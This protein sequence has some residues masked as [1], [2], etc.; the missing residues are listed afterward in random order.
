M[1]MTLTPLGDS[2]IVLVLGAT[3]DDAMLSRVRVLAHAIEHH[4]P[5]GVVD[6]VPAFGSVTVFYEIAHATGFAE[7]CAELEGI[8][9]RAEI[10]MERDVPRVVD[11]PVCYG[12]EFGPDLD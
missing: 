11:I 2:A 8:A 10:A 9:A 4:A 3:V 12:G 7:L 5:R 6:V 1:P